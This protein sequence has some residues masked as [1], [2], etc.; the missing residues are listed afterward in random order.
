MTIRR[1]LQERAHTIAAVT[2]IFAALLLPV[3]SGAGEN[4]ACNIKGNV[5][6]RGERIYHMPGQRYYDDTVIAASHGERWFC[7]EEEA[8]K[9]GWRKSKV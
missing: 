8:R 9:A 2:L 1:T 5:N 3:A 4:D 7:S 6:T